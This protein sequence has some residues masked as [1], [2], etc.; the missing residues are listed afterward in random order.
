MATNVTPGDLV[1]AIYTNSSHEQIEFDS[2]NKK[3]TWH[4]PCLINVCAND[5]VIIVSIFHNMAY[6][7][8]YMNGTHNNTIAYVVSPKIVGWVNMSNYDTR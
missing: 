3:W 7:P 6:A 5:A 2:I 4:D 1:V 8:L